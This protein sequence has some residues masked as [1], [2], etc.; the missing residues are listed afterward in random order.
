MAPGVGAVGEGEHS[1]NAITPT[2]LTTTVAGSWVIGCGTDWNALGNGTSTDVFEAITPTDLSFLAVREAAA[3]PASSTA[4][5][6]NFDA[7]GT[8]AGQ[9]TWAAVEITPTGGGT[10]AIDASSPAITGAQADPWATASFTAPV[11][12]LLVACVGCDDFNNPG[13]LNPTLTVT[14]SGLTFTEAVRRWGGETADSPGASQGVAAI[15]TAPVTA[16]QDVSRTVSVTT[17]NT[18]D[19]GA[20]KVYVVTETVSVNT[21]GLRLPMQTFRIL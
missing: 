14:S 6:L 11:D 1:S 13:S 4:V 9:W 16:G 20:I 2:V 8:G 12:S 15:F 5:T 17:S 10:L 3:T 18:N 19:T 7:A 21:S